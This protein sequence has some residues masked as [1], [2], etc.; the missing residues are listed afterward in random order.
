MKWDELDSSEKDKFCSKCEKTVY[1][2]RDCSLSEIR[3]IRRK[4]GPICAAI[5]VA[6][7]SL[8]LGFTSCSDSPKKNSPSSSGKPTE[9]VVPEDCLLGE[10][11]PEVTPPP[12]SG[13]LSPSSEEQESSS[14]E[15]KIPT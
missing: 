12:S 5:S 1:D 9:V 4:R 8:A 3:E 15:S 13:N 14:S 7:V 2:L 10:I 11:A 6:S